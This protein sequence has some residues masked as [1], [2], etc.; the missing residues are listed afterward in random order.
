MKL[1]EKHI[2]IMWGMASDIQKIQLV[3]MELNDCDKEVFNTSKRN[4]AKR[5]AECDKILAK[6]G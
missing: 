2:H 6:W 1:D 5:V 4:R 3:T